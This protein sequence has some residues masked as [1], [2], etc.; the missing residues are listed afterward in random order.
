MEFSKMQLISINRG[1]ERAIANAQKSG[2]TGIYKLPVSGPVQ[3]DPLGIPQDAICDTANHGGFDQALYI[4]GQ[5]DYAWWSTQLGQPLMPGTFGENLTISDFESAAFSLGDCL[6]I[7]S[8]LLQVTSPRIPCSTLA[9]R[10]GDPTFVKRFR[11]AERP[12]LYCR[13]LQAGTLQAGDPVTCQPYAG[14]TLTM[15]EMFRDFYVSHLSEAA[16]RRHLAAPI[17]R[18]A[19]MEMEEQLS[20]LLSQPDGATG[21]SQP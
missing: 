8:V 1:E 7:G 9:A 20:K 3:I 11:A 6:Q 12:G 13:V 4:Y 2:K 17:D 15:I 14:P 5:P 19:R 21:A 10:M 16:I 18:R